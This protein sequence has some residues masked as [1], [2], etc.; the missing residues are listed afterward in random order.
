[1]PAQDPGHGPRRHADPGTEDVLAV[2]V[3]STG[4]EHFLLDL[5]SGA[6]R[7][8]VRPGG[9]GLQTGLAL[10]GE[11]VDPGAYALAGDTHRGSD[12]CLLPAGPVALDDEHA[13]VDGQ[14]GITVG[15]ESLQGGVGP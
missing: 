4:P 3:L 1:M 2:A 7:H 9:A 12:V 15:H 10:G 11:A 14:T 5:G 6:R 8:R 13:A